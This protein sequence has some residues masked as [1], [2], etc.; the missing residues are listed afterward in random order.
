MGGKS[1]SDPKNGVIKEF[2]MEGM[3]QSEIAERLKV[4]PSHVSKTL[5]DEGLTKKTETEEESF[6]QIWDVLKDITEMKNNIRDVKEF[7]EII[8][9]YGTNNKPDVLAEFSTYGFEEKNG[10]FRKTEDDYK[11]D[12]GFQNKGAIT[13]KKTKKGE[14][15]PSNYIVIPARLIEC[16]YSEIRRRGWNCFR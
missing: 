8:A 12:V 2:Y 1:V 7:V 14:V 15:E 11:I 6:D 5:K 16:M 9:D 3:K 13:Y 10:W 4:S